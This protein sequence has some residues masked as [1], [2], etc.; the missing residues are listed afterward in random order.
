MILIVW[1]LPHSCPKFTVSLIEMHS[2][3]RPWT[4][5]MQTALYNSL[6]VLWAFSHTMQPDLL[7]SGPTTRSLEILI[8]SQESNTNTKF[9]LMQLQDRDLPWWKRSVIE[10]KAH[11]KE[12][13][14]FIQD[15]LFPGKKSETVKPK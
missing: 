11:H 2:L 7:I 9:K 10:P 12:Y 4:D 5:Q 14:D 1:N 8:I 6:Y 15:I 13:S 3:L